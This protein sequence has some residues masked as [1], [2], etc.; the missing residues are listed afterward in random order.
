VKVSLRLASLAQGRPLRRNGG[1]VDGIEASDMRKR[2]LHWPEYG[3]EALCLG[4]FMLSAAAF[5]SL[6]RHPASPLSLTV[7]SFMPSPLQRVPMGIAM[8]LTA[9]AIIYSPLGR[10]SGAHMNP[11]VTL[12]FLRLG[13]VEPHDAIAYV[14]AQFAGGA[15]GIVAATGL[16]VGLPSHPSINYVATVPGAPGTSVAFGAEAAISFGMMLMV[17]STSNAGRLARFT[18]VFA[19]LLI[20]LYIT[21]EDPLSGMSMNPARTFG[22]ALLA[23][24]ARSLWIYFTAP[25]LG[26]LAA[27][28]LYVRTIGMQH[29]LCAKLHHPTG[30]PCIFRC[31]YRLVHDKSDAQVV[32]VD[33]R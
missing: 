33:P 17:L 21:V 22:P 11:A 16:L 1:W 10:R 15:I 4:L 6:L 30:T 8:G 18:G 9:A 5:A 23:H 19:G 28:E 26:M 31:R 20:A 14:V 13:K 12:T 29:V 3:I 27:A 25:L 2:A 32:C 24:T 7:S